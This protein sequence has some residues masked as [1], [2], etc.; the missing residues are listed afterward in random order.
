MNG[1][2]NACCAWG[3]R[4]VHVRCVFRLVRCEH[5]SPCC[6]V[7][8]QFRA[9]CIGSVASCAAAR[10]GESRQSRDRCK[11]KT[12]CGC[13]GWLRASHYTG[14]L[15]RRCFKQSRLQQWMCRGGESVWGRR[16]SACLQHTSCTNTTRDSPPRS[17][18]TALLPHHTR[19]Q[20]HHMNA[21]APSGVGAGAGW[22]GGEVITHCKASERERARM[23]SCRLS[24][25]SLSLECLWIKI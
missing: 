5:T 15:L 20:Q 25:N 24:T 9:S 16:R 6:C 13:T 19:S 22:G 2:V 12:A 21:N 11:H 14:V 1:S 10:R 3:R 23:S 17:Q 4:C 18:H 8:L 7:R